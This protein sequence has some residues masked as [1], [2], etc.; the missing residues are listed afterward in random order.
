VL[1]AFFS[2]P[3][4]VNV[5]IATSSFFVDCGDKK[6]IP[7]ILFIGIFFSFLSWKVILPVN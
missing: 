1:R 6:K 3:L 7:I 4:F 5:R 2:P